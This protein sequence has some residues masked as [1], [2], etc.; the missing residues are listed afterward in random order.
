ML[1]TLYE[2]F[3]PH[4]ASEDEENAWPV[5]SLWAVHTAVLEEFLTSQYL[6]VPSFDANAYLERIFSRRINVHPVF[7]PSRCIPA[8][9]PEA[10]SRRNDP[11]LNAVALWEECIREVL[12]GTAADGEEAWDDGRCSVHDI[13]RYLAQEVN[14]SVLGNLRLHERIRRDC[15]R[16]WRHL[17]DSN[18]LKSWKSCSELKRRCV[19]D[20]RL[21][22][23]VAVFPTF[24]ERIIPYNGMWPLLVNYL[25]R[26]PRLAGKTNQWLGSTLQRHID[27]PDLVTMLMDLGVLTYDR[28]SGLYGYEPGARQ[29]LQDDL[30]E[31]WVYGI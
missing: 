16:W 6:D 4:R 24:R 28:A 21:I 27:N 7:C 10:D 25:N 12:G 1:D 26:Q 11:T 29:R 14:Y 31:M 13:A 15:A 3:L 22:A 23:L 30:N 17:K 8:D 9:D 18:T 2:V 20:A 5:T 19:R